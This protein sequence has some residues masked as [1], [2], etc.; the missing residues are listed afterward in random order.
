M[1]HI[2]TFTEIMLQHHF[3]SWGT[4]SLYM[5]IFQ[6]SQYTPLVK[7]FVHGVLAAPEL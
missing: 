6:G 3:H 5:R 7:P 4:P 2:I 1:Q